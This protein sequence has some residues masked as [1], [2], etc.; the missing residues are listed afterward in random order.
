[1][2][3]SNR[4][5]KTFHEGKIKNP[6]PVHVSLDNADTVIEGGPCLRPTNNRGASFLAFVARSGAFLVPDFCQGVA[7][8]FVAKRVSLPGPGRRSSRSFVQRPYEILIDNPQP[9]ANNNHTTIA[10]I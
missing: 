4:N 9:I 10:M 8:P 1:M 3:E 2:S 7:L 5:P 6:S